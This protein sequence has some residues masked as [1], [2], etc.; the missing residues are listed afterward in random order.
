MNNSKDNRSRQTRDKDLS[1]Y[2]PCQC[3]DKSGVFLTGRHMSWLVSS[4]IMVCFFVFISG[5]FLGKKKA[6]EKF[7][8]K[9][10]QDSF[11]DHIY[12]SMCSMYDKQDEQLG[13]GGGTEMSSTSVELADAGSTVQAPATAPQEHDVAPLEDGGKKACVVADNGVLP[14]IEV[15]ERCQ[16]YAELIGFGTERAARK[17]ADKLLKNNVTVSVKRRRSK[18]A[19]G[20]VI[21]WYQVV[22]GT[23]DDKDDLIALVD[24]V[25]VRE[26]LKDVRIVSC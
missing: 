18:T 13:Q 6:V 5:Y 19:R 12:Y 15:K 9:I 8:H 22:T 7:Y 10:K 3:G 21:T 1:G 2:K 17:F 26:R 24:D 16:Y 11:A 14:E 4:L 25:S 23:F 20:R